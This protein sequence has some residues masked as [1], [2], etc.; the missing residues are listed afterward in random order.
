MSNSLRQNLFKK[1]IK[2]FQKQIGIWSCLSNNTI[3]EIIGT[4][5]FDWVVIDMEHSP[6]DI[7]EV[8]AQ[9]Q[10]INGFK[11]EPIVRVPWNEPV[12]VKRVLDMGAQTILF[13]YIENEKEAAEAVSA[14][15]YPPKGIFK[16][17]IIIF[18]ININA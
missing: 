13:P 16:I 15:R 2:L 12:I 18:H 17:A 3:V 8:L 14:T 1:N 7:S 11:T 5:G 4:V 6:N 9:L 10:V